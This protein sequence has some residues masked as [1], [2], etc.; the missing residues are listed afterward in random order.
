MKVLLQ[1]RI[2]QPLRAS[3]GL[4]TSTCFQARL[5]SS[6]LRVPALAGIYGFSRRTFMNRPGW[7][8]KGKKILPGTP[9][10][11]GRLFCSPCRHFT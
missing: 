1:T 4:G 9:G 6:P 2:Y 8:Q 5:R 11:G 3:S 10:G 7:P